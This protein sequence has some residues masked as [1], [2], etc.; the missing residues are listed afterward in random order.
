MRVPRFVKFAALAV[1][2]TLLLPVASA[3]AGGRGCKGECYEEVPAP[4]YY[5]TFKRRITYRPGVYEIAREPSLYGWATRRVVLDDGIEW[6]ERPAVYKTV[7][8]RKHLRSRT[9]WQK[10]WVNG[11]HIMCKV[12]VPGRTVWVHKKVLVSH[13]HRWKV[14]S[15]PVYGYVKKRILLKQYKNI[16]IYRRPHERYV[17]EQVRIEPESTAWVPFR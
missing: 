1:C 12:R 15:A 11:R 14:R 13:A 8:V 4:A 3:F 17:R 9:T 5:R 6:R 16:A 2:G 7:K 10:R